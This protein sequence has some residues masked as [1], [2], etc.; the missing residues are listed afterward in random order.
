MEKA[1]HAGL[2]NYKGYNLAKE[3]IKLDL[4][5]AIEDFETRDSDIFIITYPKSGKNSVI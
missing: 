2:F 1:E 4:L 3:L 5:E